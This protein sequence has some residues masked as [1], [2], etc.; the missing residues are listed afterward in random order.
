[1]QVP[2]IFKIK[3]PLILKHGW[4]RQVDVYEFKS[5]L[6]N[7]ARF[8]TARAVTERNLVSKNKNKFV[9]HAVH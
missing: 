9:S 6:V 8:R 1:M 2:W 3:A 5:S 4:Q 7:K